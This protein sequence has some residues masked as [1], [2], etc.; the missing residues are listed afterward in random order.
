M[1]GE[2]QQ[3]LAFP[4][5]DLYMDRIG[6]TE[7]LRPSAAVFLLILNNFFTLV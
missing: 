1:P 4:H 2:G 3:E 5:P 6:I 7:D